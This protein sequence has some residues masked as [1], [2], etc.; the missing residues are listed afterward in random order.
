MA[1]DNNAL[2]HLPLDELRRL[3]RSQPESG[4]EAMAKAS[5]LRTLE[6]LRRE[7]RQQPTPPPEVPP[8]LDLDAPAGVGVYWHHA[9]GSPWEELDAGCTVG[10]RLQQWNNMG[11][12]EP[13]IR[14]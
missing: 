6:R 1:P 12:P 7:Q 5:A 11:R 4:R 10:F 14:S 2:D 13:F 8:D 9:P 3:A